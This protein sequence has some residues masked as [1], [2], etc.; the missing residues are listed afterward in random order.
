MKMQVE[1]GDLTFEQM[2]GVSLQDLFIQTVHANWPAELRLSRATTLAE[3]QRQFDH[4]SRDRRGG[5]RSRPLGDGSPGFPGFTAKERKYVKRVGVRQLRRDAK[6]EAQRQVREMHADERYW[7]Q[8]LS[9]YEEDQRRDEQE[10]YAAYLDGYPDDD[11]YDTYF[12]DHY[13]DYLDNYPEDRGY[14]VDYLHWHQQADEP[15]IRRIVKC[16]PKNLME[17]DYSLD[18]RV[19]TSADRGMTLGEL[20]RQHLENRA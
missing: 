13:D 4:A 8:Q 7:E 2:K 5:H 17:C 14:D 18:D 10:E 11:P 3:G 15:P 1:T 6:A 19:I 20:L 12:D 16:T 9:W